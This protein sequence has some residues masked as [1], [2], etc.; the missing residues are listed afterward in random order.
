MA[1][2]STTTLKIGDMAPQFSLL[3]ANGGQTSTLDA[4]VT[5]G[6]LIIEFLR[7]TW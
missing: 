1:L 3:A 2:D 6:P 5:R 4:L 7:G